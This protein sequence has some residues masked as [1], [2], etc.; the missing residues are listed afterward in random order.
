MLYLDS[1][2]LVKRY[3]HEHGSTAITS[4]F[5]SGEKI[6]TSIL[7]FAEVHA[8]I[9]RKY[10]VGELNV[11]ERDKLVDEFQA[12]WLF[13]L[14]ILELTTNTMSALPTICE[15]YSL[16][17]SDAIHLSAAFW[18]KDAT[19]L[20]VKG[21]DDEGIVVEFGVSDRQLGEAALKCGFKVF[22]PASIED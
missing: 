3:V 16:K 1:S 20:H 13:S 10:R 5:E 15:R 14:S 2:A 7:S 9:G 11:K 21:F 8:A 22:D 19:R 17:A 6:Y 18:M 12:D 4:R